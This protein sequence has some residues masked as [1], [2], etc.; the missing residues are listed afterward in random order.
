MARGAVAAALGSVSGTGSSAMNP[1]VPAGTPAQVTA[2]GTLVVCPDVRGNADFC[3]DGDTALMPAM[4]KGAIADAAKAA[5][6]FGRAEREAML[7]R[8]AAEARA[9]DLAAERAGVLA[10]LDAAAGSRAVR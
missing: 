5:L 8:A 4:E 6:G 10:V 7:G 1:V 2:M 9:H 3:R